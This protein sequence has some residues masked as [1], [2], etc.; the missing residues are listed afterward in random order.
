MACINVYRNHVRI[1]D[2]LVETTSYVTSR[3]AE[4]DTYCV[5]AVYDLGESRGSNYVKLGESSL[6]S[7]VTTVMKL[8][9]VGHTLYVYGEDE[10]SVYTPDGRCVYSGQNDMIA[11]QSAGVYIV[12]TSAGSSK[13]V[14]R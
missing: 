13:I 10:T 5:T 12:R 9:V 14:V 1:N 3:S 2:A 6:E 4:T 11:L 7:V 8:D